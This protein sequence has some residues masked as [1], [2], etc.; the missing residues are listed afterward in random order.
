MRLDDD[1]D[2]HHHHH[3]DQQHHILTMTMY[4]TGGGRDGR[5]AGASEPGA[6]GVLA[7]P[8]GRLGH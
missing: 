7:W 1:D 8:R 6:A 4:A 5:D 2:D 3:H